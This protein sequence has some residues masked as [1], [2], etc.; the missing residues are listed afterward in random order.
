MPSGNELMKAS[1][2]DTRPEATAPRADYYRRLDRKSAAPLW[3]VL[4][5]IVTPEP[6]SA[7]VAA[8]WRY[9]EMRPLLM[10]AGALITAKEAERRVVVLENPGI[11]GISQI[12]QSLYAGLQLVLPGETAPTHRHTASALRF[13]IE[14]DGGYTAV[15][16]ERTTMRPGDFIVTPPWTFHDHGNTTTRPIVWLDVLD[17]P[18]VNQLCCSFAEHYDDETQPLSRPEGD[19][20]DRF[21]SNMVPLEFT[22]RGLDSPVLSFPY[23]R[24]RETL[25]RLARTGPVHPSHG[26]KMQFVNPVTGG[27]AMTTIGTFLQLLPAGF[28]GKPYRSTDATI[29][30]VAEGQGESTIGGQVFAWGP[31]DVFVVPSWCPV[32]HNAR[33]EAVLFSASDRPVQKMLHMWREQ[34]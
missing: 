32:S 9:E 21:G 27:Y 5:D 31:H 13:V 15:D 1:A 11:R 19:S 8:L 3:E 10:E 12:T 7:C 16:G 6:R 24:S 25:H 33:G 20:L 14:S 34:A 18:I 4:A 29:Y 22:P 23:S 30:C 28:A 2:L 17:I 26:V